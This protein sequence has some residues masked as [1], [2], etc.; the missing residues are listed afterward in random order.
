M[1]SDALSNSA[2]PC[3]LVSCKCDQSPDSRQ[4]DPLL[5]EQLGTSFGPGMGGI[6]SFQTSAAY[7]ESHKRCISIILRAIVSKESGLSL[8]Q[9]ISLSSLVLRLRRICLRYSCMLLWLDLQREGKIMPRLGRASVTDLVD[10]NLNSNWGTDVLSIVSPWL[11]HPFSIR[12][13]RAPDAITSEACIDVDPN[14]CT[15]EVD[16]WSVQARS[17]ELRIIE[18]SVWRT[19]VRAS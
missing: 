18:F 16:S 1:S 15:S 17:S 2:I 13:D 10:V 6:D 7:P 19:A 11:T 12:R 9:S 3:V 14:M 5:I 4:L 8:S